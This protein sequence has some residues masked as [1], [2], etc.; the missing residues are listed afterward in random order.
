MPSQGVDS[1]PTG[2]GNGIARSTD[3]PASL[4]EFVSRVGW[5]FA[6]TMPEIPH[7][8]TV[9]AK[10]TAGV[11]PV[12]DAWYVWFTEQIAEH[13]YQAKFGGSTYTYLHVDGC[14]YWSLS[15]RDGVTIIN[16]ARLPD[17]ATSALRLAAAPTSRRTT[18]PVGLVI[19]E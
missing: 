3:L 15:G 9:A 6:S 18:S 19:T 17:Q 16:R 5:R 1:R 4:E 12:P 7:E 14:K 10:A 11:P 8:Y 13:G 2:Q